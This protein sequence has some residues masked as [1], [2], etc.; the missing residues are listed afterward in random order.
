[1]DSHPWTW[2]PRLQVTLPLLATAAAVLVL[3][4]KLKATSGEALSRVRA[5]CLL[6]PAELVTVPV[7]S[8]PVTQ[9]WGFG[10][11]TKE[12]VELSYSCCAGGR[13]PGV[14]GHTGVCSLRS[15]PV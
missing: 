5:G 8:A 13:G 11:E 15:T 9:D 1:M 4:G 2:C 14:P 10:K 6:S 7:V 3:G 12:R